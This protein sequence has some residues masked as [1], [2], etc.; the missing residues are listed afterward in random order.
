MAMPLED[1][2]NAILNLDLESQLTGD[3]MKRSSIRELLG[4]NT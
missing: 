2:D 3:S 1:T 4:A